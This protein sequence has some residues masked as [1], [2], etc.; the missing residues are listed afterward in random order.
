MGAYV[1]TSTSVIAAKYVVIPEDDTVLPPTTSKL[2]KYITEV[3]CSGLSKLVRSKGFLKPLSISMLFNNNKPLYSVFNPNNQHPLVIR[4]GVPLT[5]KVSAVVSNGSLGI[6]DFKCI[7]GC[8]QTPYGNFNLEL[9]ELEI[10]KP[11][12]LSVGLRKY[13]KISYLTPTLITAKYM[14]PPMLKTRSRELPERHKL[15]PQPSFLF[16][17]LLR[18]WNSIV[19]PNEKIPNCSAGDLEAYKLGRLA[20]I[21]LI[22]VDYRLR[23]ITVVV[24]KD[25]GGRLRTARGFTGWVIYESLTPT[26]KLHS[27]FDKLLALAKYLGVG[28]SRGIGF[29]MIDITN[30]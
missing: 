8:W 6:E 29:G 30:L 20:D 18:L 16:S 7:E 22:E 28:R 9:A 11:D 19:G 27:T 13:F 14:I 12:L 4:G 26:N 24:G 10:I 15:I 17:Y 23:P 1:M 3:S 25:D 21:T 2:I 5:A